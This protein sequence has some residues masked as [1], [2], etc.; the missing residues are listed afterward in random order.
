[1]NIDSIVSDGTT[2]GNR[3]RGPGADI[4]ISDAE[5]AAAHGGFRRT[6]V[7]NDGALAGLL[8]PAHQVPTRGLASK[9]KVLARQHPR[10]FG[11]RQ[12]R[13]QMRGRDLQNVYGMAFYVV[14][15]EISSQPGF[16]PDHVE[17]TARDEGREN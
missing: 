4:I 1:Q 6:V 8:Y 5:G 9:N 7:I 12:Q 17:T 3:R 15:E 10:T 14:A 16:V 11:R 2:D 13:A